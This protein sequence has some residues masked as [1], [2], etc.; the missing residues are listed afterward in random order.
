MFSRFFIDRPIFAGST[1]AEPLRSTRPFKIIML[2]NSG[3]SMVTSVPDR[4]EKACSFSSVMI[5]KSIV[6][7]CPKDCIFI[8]S[9]QDAE[10]RR[11][12]KQ[13]SKA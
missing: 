13:I 1:Y 7:A 6:G 3:A 8:R 4:S 11:K 9:K 2:P 5:E 12:H 10:P